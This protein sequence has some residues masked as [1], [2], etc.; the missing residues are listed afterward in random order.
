MPVSRSAG[1]TSRDPQLDLAALRISANDLPQVSSADSSK[2]R[3]GEL[4]IA[5]GNPLG[6]VGAL[7]TGVIHAVGP[8]GGNGS[9]AAL[10]SAKDWAADRIRLSIKAKLPGVGL[11]PTDA[12]T[13]IGIER[14]ITQ[15]AGETDVAFAARLLNAWNVWPYAGTARHS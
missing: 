3:P 5:I 2:L 6:F 11:A 15:N 13:Q 9:R 4:A 1:I 12:L 14:G 8:L 10:A 7:T